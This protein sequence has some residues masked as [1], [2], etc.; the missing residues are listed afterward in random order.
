ME[1]HGLGFVVRP[2]NIAVVAGG[3]LMK[4]SALALT[5]NLDGQAF[6]ARVR[7]VVAHEPPELMLNANRST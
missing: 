6:D 5:V 2:G 1:V 4:L 7:Y 3:F